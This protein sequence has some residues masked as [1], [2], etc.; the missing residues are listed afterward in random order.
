MGSWNGT[1][2]LTSLPIHEGERVVMFVLSMHGHGYRVDFGGGTCE[3]H[4]HAKP[5]GPALRGTYNGYG[6][7]ANLEGSALPW[8]EAYLAEVGQYLLNE[9]GEPH[10]FSSIDDFINNEETGVE[11]GGVYVGIPEMYDTNARLGLMLVH[12]G[13]YNRFMATALAS[14]DWMFVDPT[15][16]PVTHYLKDLQ[17]RVDEVAAQGL[18]EAISRELACAGYDMFDALESVLR[19]AA[20]GGA[21][22]DLLK[23]VACLRIFDMMLGCARK[24]WDRQCG[25]GSDNGDM[26]LQLELARFTLEFAGSSS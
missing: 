7:V 14:N 6:G 2:A 11:R 3:A 13:A 15:E 4:T 22:T 25:A 23:E 21:S 9:D 16:D 1:C 26:N 10:E 24:S 19:Y 17:D 20:A 8:W 18:D 12:E 5:M